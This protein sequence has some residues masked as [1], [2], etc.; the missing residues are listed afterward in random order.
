MPAKYFLHLRKPSPHSAGYGGLIGKDS[1]RK[2]DLNFGLK[3][4]VCLQ[5]WGKGTLS[6]LR[7]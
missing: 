1:K 2:R 5:E 3:D 6:G 4:R 7:D